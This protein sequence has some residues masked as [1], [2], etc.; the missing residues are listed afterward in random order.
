MDAVHS[1][2][3][4]MSCDAS[5]CPPSSPAATTTT[6]TAAT[7]FNQP[8]SQ[9]VSVD[10]LPKLGE[11]SDDGQTSWHERAGWRFIRSCTPAWFTVNMG[12]GIVGILLQ[13]LPYNGRWLYWISIIFFVLNVVL[14]VIFVVT[15]ALRY[16]LYPGLWSTTLRHPV[17]PLFLGAFPIALSTIIEMMILVCGPAWGQWAIIF[18]WALWWIDIVVSI[19][20]CYGVP[21]YIMYAQDIQLSNVTAAWLL[22]GAS[23]IVAAGVGGVVAEALENTQHALWTLLVSYF[24]WGTAMP[25]SVSLMVIYLHRLFV[26]KLP[27]REVIVSSLLPVAALGQGGFGILQF[28]KVAMEVFPQNGIFATPSNSAGQVLYTIGWLISILM[29]SYGSFWLAIA[30]MSMARGR[31][32]FNLSWWS[33]TFPLGV[34]A[35]TAV[36]FGEEMPSTFFK[37]FGTVVSIIVTLLW[38]V[39]ALGTLR[40]V[41]NGTIFAAP[42]FEAWRKSRNNKPE[43]I[44]KV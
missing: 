41:I 16:T 26:H 12:T 17:V 2:V 35:S 5:Q 37:V 22:P 1:Q 20:I 9:R 11:L 29:W 6:T 19:A 30:I 43:I 23:V 21:F 27:P 28:G 15:S 13:T 10:H 39:V 24:L 25:I 34:W 18:A 36:A 44:E 4:E 32:A 42:D 40:G 14:F 8:N 3:D 38:V 31:F 33:F 7:T